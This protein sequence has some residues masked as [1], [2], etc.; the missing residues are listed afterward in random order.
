[1]ITKRGGEALKAMIL[2]TSSV[3][4]GLS[5]TGLRSLAGVAMLREYDTGETL[6]LQDEQAFGF[7][8]LQQGTV[9]VYRT[10]MDGRRQILHVFDTPGDVCGEVPVFEGS[11]YPA[12]ADVVCCSH[13]IYLPRADFMAVTRMHPEILLQMLAILSKRLRRFVGLI[14]DLSLKDVAARLAK[15][16]YDLSIKE[17]QVEFRLSTTKGMLAARLGTIAETVSRTLRKLQAQG[18]IS[19]DG[20]SIRILDAAGLAAVAEGLR[21][22]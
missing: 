1:M 4:D 14:D 9:N 13:L 11:T 5:E 22:R 3:F 18:L 2:R 7:Y 12:T 10:G 19:V 6:F 17:G 8:V 15:H 20:R 16:L 21:T